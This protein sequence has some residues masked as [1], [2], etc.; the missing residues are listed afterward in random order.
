MNLALDFSV[1]TVDVTRESPQG[2]PLPPIN[3]R[4]IAA[5]HASFTGAVHAC[6]ARG[7]KLVALRQLLTHHGP[8]TINEVA[9]ITGWPLSSVCSLKSALPDVVPDGFEVVEWRA[10]KAT[11]RT[12]WIIR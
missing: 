12:R 4:T 10:G 3:G 5:R 6:H 9:A 8:L 2:E 1:P 11:K 7:E